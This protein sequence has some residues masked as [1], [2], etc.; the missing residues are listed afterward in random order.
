MKKI[1]VLLFVLVLLAA[2][3]PIVGN[4]LVSSVLDEKIE[5]LHDNGIDVKDTIVE[6]SYLHTKIHYEFLLQE[7]EKF[8]AYL[9]QS[10]H[11]EIPSYIQDA[12]DGVLLG[13][14]VSYSNVPFMNNIVVDI[15]PIKLSSNT[16]DT[17]QE[18]DKNFYNFVNT[19]L[20][21]K[22]IL[23]N[24]QYDMI[25]EGFSGYLKDINESYVDNDGTNLKFSLVG[26]S[27]QGS[28]NL[29]AP[30]I[31]SSQ[32]QTI[33]IEAIKDTFEMKFNLLD[34][35]TESEFASKSKYANAVTL[36]SF[37]LSMS[38]DDNVSMNAKNVQVSMSADTQDAFAQ[39]YAKSSFEQMQVD[40]NA[41]KASM[42]G[43]NYDI[44]IVDLDKDALEELQDIL[45]EAKNSQ[46]EI[47]ELKMKE[48]FIKLL[49]RGVTLNIDDFSFKKLVL[50][51]TQDLKGISIS[52]EIT[53][54]EDPALANKLLYTP[55][56]LA[57]NLDTDIKLKIS[58]EIFNKINETT[59]IAALVLQ[60]AKEEANNLVFEM[61]MH[62][63]E[64]MINGRDIKR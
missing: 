38:G 10:S 43:F 14:D 17:L 22:G 33:S 9:N 16:M 39:I 51:K 28:G 19:F 3:L 5:L 36:G 49:S 23:Y 13:V 37:D 44:S 12:I 54:K 62:D 48:S 47:L 35:H 15:Y 63:G 64:V 26:M 53:F 41:L 40:A 8:F 27:Y 60:Y 18:S 46:S 1:L 45:G 32:L 56:L 58:K 11:G 2:A 55:A 61:I 57:Q 20:S 24:L 7:S 50:D 25:S 30:N 21:K 29:I 31:L 42:E 59:P 52:S 4:K 6:S 34:L